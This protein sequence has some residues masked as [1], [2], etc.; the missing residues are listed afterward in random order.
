V[1][2]PPTAVGTTSPPVTATIERGRLRLFAKAVGQTDPAYVDVTAAQAA[3][4]RDLPVPP[5]YLFGLELEQPDPFAW[6]RELGVDMSTVLHG[7]QSFSYA[8]MAYAGDELTVQSTI[9]GVQS[10][11]AGALELVDRRSEVTRRGELIAVL[12]QTIVVRNAVAA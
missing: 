7:T 3:G 5:T 9:T 1:A 4:Y 12:E 6:V 2:I 8:A 10:K 11:K